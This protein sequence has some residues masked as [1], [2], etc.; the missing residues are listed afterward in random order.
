[1]PIKAENFA[2]LMPAY[3]LVKVMLSNVPN[4]NQIQ[5]GRNSIKDFTPQTR[6]TFF[7]IFFPLPLT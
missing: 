2:F 5:T 6:L 4:F 3:R 1:V 7:F